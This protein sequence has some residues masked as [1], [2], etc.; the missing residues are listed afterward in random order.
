[1]KYLCLVYGE[2]EKIGAMTDDECMEYEAAIRRSG[3]CIASE[4]LQRIS[5]AK[6]VR[7]R[8]FIIQEKGQK[9]AG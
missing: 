7:V 2:E 8:S 1:M 4:A 3:L 5:T 6:I 9:C